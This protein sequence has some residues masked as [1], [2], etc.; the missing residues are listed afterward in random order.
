M[1]NDKETGTPREERADEPVTR[2]EDTAPQRVVLEHV[3][4]LRRETSCGFVNLGGVYNF[5]P[6][7]ADY[8]AHKAPPPPPVVEP[9]RE[10]SIPPLLKPPYPK[11]NAK[12]AELVKGEPLL[13]DCV[14]QEWLEMP[15]AYFA[16]RLWAADDLV[17]VLVGQRQATY[18]LQEVLRKLEL[19]NQLNPQPMRDRRSGE[20][21]E[22]KYAVARFE[23]PKDIGKQWLRVSFLAKRLHL[24]L[25]VLD[26][27]AMALEGWFSCV[28]QDHSDLES[29]MRLAVELGADPKSASPRWAAAHMPAGLSAR[30]DDGQARLALQSLRVVRDVYDW[31][32]R[33]LAGKNLVLRFDPQ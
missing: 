25:L 16:K 11:G 17:T 5:Y 15:S 22:W 23:T 28:G 13:A 26:P 18:S 32:K 9:A 6:S 31:N 10:P 29:F 12:A 24:T 1:N 33:H 20:P 14:Q 21:K 30:A 27:A 7:E 4:T 2:Q 3:A 19:Y 8:F